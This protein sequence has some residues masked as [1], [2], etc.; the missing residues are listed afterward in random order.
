MNEEERLKLENRIQSVRSI[1]KLNKE[2]SIQT[3][4]D[5]IYDIDFIE[6]SADGFIYA[7]VL[8][9]RSN[10]KAWIPYEFDVIK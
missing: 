7:H 6:L 9:T 10:L 4:S 5:E 3:K 1:I 8:G 2:V